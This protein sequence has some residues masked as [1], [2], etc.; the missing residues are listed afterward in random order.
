MIRT[1]YSSLIKE[2]G[3]QGWWPI[4]GKYHK[5]DYSYPRNERERYE[6]IVGAILTQN[7]SWKQVEKA[8]ENLGDITPRKILSMKDLK[9]KIKPA[10][11]FNQKAGYLKNITEFFIALKGRTPTRKELL[12]VKGVGPETA[13]SIL[14]YAY[15][16]PE[17]VVDAYT[18]RI[19]KLNKTY[20]EI[21]ELFEKNLPKNVKLYQEYHAL[22]VEHAKRKFNKVSKK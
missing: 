21:K 5:K 12:A 15:N 9:E 6:I 11:Y 22:I 14:L 16:Q 8:L 7:T 20:H 10:G 4:K 19:F 13:D 3:P 1:K 18:K 2:Y 17:F